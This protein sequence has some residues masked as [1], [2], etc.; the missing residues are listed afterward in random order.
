MR[1]PVRRRFALIAAGAGAAALLA[2]APVLPTASA[3]P[4]TPDDGV[5][6]V[7]DDVLGK[8]P[9]P[10]VTPSAPVPPPAR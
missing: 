10:T 1:I 4:R 3:Q 2:S 7:V 9:K 6:D 5:L 8:S